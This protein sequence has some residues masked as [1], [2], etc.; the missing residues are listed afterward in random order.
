MI[1]LPFPKS[2]PLPHSP[3]SHTRSL[4][5][6]AIQPYLKIIMIMRIATKIKV[7]FFS[8][9][10]FVPFWL[11]LTFLERFYICKFYYMT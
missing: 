7:S 5:F 10:G 9:I 8:V 3:K 6:I 1:S 11:F 4:S 2:S